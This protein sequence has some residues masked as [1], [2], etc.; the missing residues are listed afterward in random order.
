MIND[1][2][3]PVRS[4]DES[5]AAPATDLA[6]SLVRLARALQNATGATRVLKR[7]GG[8]LAHLNGILEPLGIQRTEGSHGGVT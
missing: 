1:P 3:R 7:R 6:P 5:F 2:R 8:V 4:A